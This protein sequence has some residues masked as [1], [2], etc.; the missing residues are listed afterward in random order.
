MKVIARAPCARAGRTVIA[1]RP[2]APSARAER[3]EKEPSRVVMGLSVILRS[4]GFE[5]TSIR[6]R[7]NRI[8]HGTGHFAPVACQGISS[9]LR[10]PMAK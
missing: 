8:T 2:P 9:R 5:I 10:R 1:A 6:L 3:R 7:G 4:A